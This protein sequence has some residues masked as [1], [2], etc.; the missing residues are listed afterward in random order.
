M[1]YIKFI[2]IFNIIVGFMNM[3]LGFLFHLPMSVTLGGFMVLLSVVI[4]SN[5]RTERLISSLR[6]EIVLL[7][8]IDHGNFVNHNKRKGGIHKE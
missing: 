3:I 6:S 2:S 4:E 8:I 5:Y 1:N 7:S